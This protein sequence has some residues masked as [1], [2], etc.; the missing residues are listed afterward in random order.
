VDAADGSPAGPIATDQLLTIFGNGLGPAT[1]VTATNNTT[2]SLG[3]VSVSFGGVEAPLLYVSS[4]Q[5]N[6]AVP[7]TTQGLMNTAIKVTVNGVSSPELVFPLT[8]AIA[9]T[10]VV[11]GGFNQT[12]R[13][14]A[15]LAL[16]ADGSVNSSANPAKTGSVISVFVNGLVSA[17]ATGQLQLISGSGWSVTNLSQDGPFVMVVNLQVPPTTA[18]MECPAPDSSACL[19]SF[20]VDD[21]TSFLQNAGQGNS[22]GVAF[23]GLVY[24]AP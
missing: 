14:F 8:A 17:Q 1:P 11:P 24:V 3:G 20:Q 15:T 12:F 18:N 10:F 6:V 16:N 2:T 7:Q 13:N 9:S 5:I 4:N 23:S 22:G 19:G 21:L